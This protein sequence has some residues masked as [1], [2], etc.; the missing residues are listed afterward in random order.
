MYLVTEKYYDSG[1]TYAQY[2]EYQD[3]QFKEFEELGSCDIYKSLVESECEAKEI[4]EECLA[5]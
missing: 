5:A 1:K 4:V 2:E 3:Q